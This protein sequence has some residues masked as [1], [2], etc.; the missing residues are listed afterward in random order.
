[1]GYNYLDRYDIKLIED[2]MTCL[3]DL[4]SVIDDLIGVAVNDTYDNGFDDGYSKCLED[5]DMGEE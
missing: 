4:L 2:N 3:E 5:Y 1:M